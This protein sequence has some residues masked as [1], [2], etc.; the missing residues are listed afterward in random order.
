MRNG[1]A[2]EDPGTLKPRL[3]YS[4]AEMDGP[5]LPFFLG[6]SIARTQSMRQRQLERR[7]PGEREETH[8]VRR[9]K[10]EGKEPA[11]RQG[12]SQTI[13]GMRRGARLRPTPT[14]TYPSNPPG[15]LKP[16]ACPPTD[17][18]VY[19]SVP[20]EGQTHEGGSQIKAG[21]TGVWARLTWPVTGGSLR[22]IPP[23]GG[24]HVSG[25]SEAASPKS[26]SPTRSLAAFAS[27]RSVGLR[28]SERVRELLSELNWARSKKNEWESRRRRRR[29]RF[30]A[31]NFVRSP[32]CPR[33]SPARSRQG[34]SSPAPAPAPASPPPP[35][36]PLLS[37]QASSP[38]AASRSSCC[39][40]QLRQRRQRPLR[41][42]RQRRR[43][44]PQSSA[45]SML[46]GRSSGNRRDATAAAKLAD[47][48][49]TLGRHRHACI[50]PSVRPSD[51]GGDDDCLNGHQP[52]LW[53][54]HACACC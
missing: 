31:A 21:D 54:L 10:K 8:R 11:Q 46:S 28:V 24:L 2:S 27:L 47:S 4:G 33:L 50:R 13:P 36:P 30:L 41:R 29:S 42:R 19:S 52:T 53:T 16:A 25:A 37:F 35:P 17:P 22:R 5:I 3:K 43:R 6:G 18:E 23:P 15:G 32:A 48:G 20:F 14:W 39:C 1:L 44:K 40:L 45:T 34:G 38:P 12:T 9:E 26:V 49:A 51:H 7:Q